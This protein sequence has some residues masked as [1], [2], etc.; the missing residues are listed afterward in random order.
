MADVDISDAILTLILAIGRG[1][2]PDP[3][4]EHRAKAAVPFGGKFRVIDFTLTN[5]LRSGLRQALILT[6]YKSH[7]LHKHLRDGW[8][9][10]NSELGEFILPV[11]PQMREGASWY[12]GPLDAIRQNRYLLERNPAEH[13]LVLDG[14]AVYRM[15][16]AELA[17]THLA[18]GAA[19]TVA[20]R[21]ECE[22]G[23]AMSGPSVLLDEHER[24]LCISDAMPP[25]V[26]E[27]SHRLPPEQLGTMGVY[28]FSKAALLS[29]LEH[30]EPDPGVTEQ[31]PT[32]ADAETE[33][34]EAQ[35]IIK[36][37]GRDLVGP[38]CETHEV[39][40]YRFGQDRGRVMPDRYW[41]DLASVDAYYEANMALLR[42][43]PPLNLYQSDWNI[44]TYQGQHPPARTVP[45]ASSGNEG[46]F[47]NS[48]LAAGTVISGGG[49]NHCILFPL[50]KVE[51]GAI[52]ED[53]I[54]FDGVT[55]GAGAH[56]RHCIVEKDVVVPPRAEV[57]IDPR[58]D[59]ERFSVSPQG[60]V[61]VPKGYRWE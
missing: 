12:Q 30:L 55:V 57:G 24:V 42:A 45:G 32:A 49:V 2:G 28:L 19:V 26:L 51:D 41:C 5:C 7:S 54:L 22:P 38:L 14:E 6:Q 58:R 36:H 52:V 10:F 37:L 25:H 27:A 47:V 43:D 56:L 31:A 40:A 20:V 33:G 61:V 17:R 39:R 15:D 1:Q 34:D 46:I 60:V 29:A 4:T 44:R 50:V 8:S 59:R 21:T 13:V 18:S 9:I 16:Y 11:P 48:M 35:V 3:L 23:A 53:S